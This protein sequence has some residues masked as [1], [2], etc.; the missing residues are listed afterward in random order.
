MGD[1]PEVESSK[2]GGAP[3]TYTPYLKLKNFSSGQKWCRA[4]YFGY[5]Q[6]IDATSQ[7]K[8]VVVQRKDNLDNLYP[9]MTPSDNVMS[10]S[11]SEPLYSPDVMSDSMHQ[12]Q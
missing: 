6:P 11:Q 4:V 5:S 10:A 1:A 3:C 8:T 12:T 9:I 2:G 7:F